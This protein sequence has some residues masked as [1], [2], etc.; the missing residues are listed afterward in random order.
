MLTPERLKLL[1]DYDSTTGRLVRKICN[2]GEL[3]VTQ[4]VSKQ[5]YYIRWVDKK[6][7]TEHRLVFIYHNGYNPI[8][9]DH[10]NG[11]KL[12]NRVGNLRVCDR[13]QNNANSVKKKRNG[14]HSSSRKGVYFRESW[15][16]SGKWI[17]QIVCDKKH[18]WLGK[19]D[20]E[21]EASEAYEK[22]AIELFGKFAYSSRMS[23]ANR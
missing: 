14:K 8:E 18:H 2:K 20:T 7:Y 23:H 19:F 5:G 4:G 9:I 3:P 11:N 15:G 21:S 12:D 22:A 1:F 17:A 16:P 6:C 10:A 13:T